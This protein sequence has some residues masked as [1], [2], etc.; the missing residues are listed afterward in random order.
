MLRERLFEVKIELLCL[1]LLAITPGLDDRTQGALR[2]TSVNDVIWAEVGMLYDHEERHVMN[3]YFLDGLGGSMQ[4]GFGP[5]G[6][7][8]PLDE[9]EKHLLKLLQITQDLYTSCVDLERIKELLRKK[10]ELDDEI[11][12]DA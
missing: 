3:R 8:L 5:C 7:Q 12:V 2:H 1:R 6:T 11:D 9:D 10:K 4:E